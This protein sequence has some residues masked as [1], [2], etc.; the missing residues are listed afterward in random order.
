MAEFDYEYTCPKIDKL[1]DRAKG[2]MANFIDGLLEEACPLLDSRERRRIADEKAEGAYGAIEDVLEGVRA[3]NEKMRE[4]A[5][6]QI[7][8]LTEE[9]ADAKLYAKDGG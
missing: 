7:R 4:A 6:R 5:E 9:L 1:I 2:E 8:A 3:T